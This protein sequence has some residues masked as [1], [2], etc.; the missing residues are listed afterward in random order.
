M[1]RVSDCVG[2]L[3]RD[4]IWLFKQVDVLLSLKNPYH[5][6]NERNDNGIVESKQGEGIPEYKKR[7]YR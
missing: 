4:I 6:S 7:T 3:I 5:V 1:G 2:S